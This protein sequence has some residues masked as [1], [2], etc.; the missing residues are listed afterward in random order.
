MT[1]VTT[2]LALLGGSP[3]RRDP[4]P[5]WP[6]HGPRER[7]LLLAVLESGNWS[8]DGPMETEF[9]GR[10]ARLCGTAYGFG[11]PNGTLSLE[12]ALRALGVGPG[13]EV[14]LSA[15]SFGSPAW[16]VVQVGAVPVFADIRESDW[17]LDPA[18]V[19]A[20]VTPATR[21]LLP[22][23]PF[24]QLADLDS[25]LDI[26]GEHSLRVLE[27]CAH[28]HGSGWQGGRSAGGLGDIGSFSFQQSKPMTAGEGAILVTSD[29]ALAHRIY[30]LR[31]LGRQWRA[32]SEPGFGGN[33]RITEFQAAVL[34]AQ[35]DRLDDQIARKTGNVDLFRDRIRAVP[36][37]HPL[38]AQPQVA[39]QNVF[40]LPVRI[41][42]GEFQHVPVSRLVAA[43]AAEGLPVRP[44]D[45]VIYQA[46]TWLSGLRERRWPAAAD[47][48]RQLGLGAHCPVAERVSQHGL[49]IRQTAFLGGG[50]DV[51][52]I[53][54][55]F[56]KVRRNAKSL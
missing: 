6:V 55:A 1:S 36:G 28:V 19:R 30:G 18:S 25:L 16:A 21:A 23:H 53:V 26:A 37:V 50:A 29:E 49:V 22:V 44:A 14:I 27:D 56:D 11:L 12:I 54:A 7:E 31:N 20:L 8:Y 51:D 10:F 46:P 9:I 33:Y 47:P 40:G 38:A 17:C 4:F 45:P 3:L 42:P 43:L 34:L 5:S 48:A 35:L 52:D 41:E 15:L 39:R 13:D 2:E 32:D 24:C